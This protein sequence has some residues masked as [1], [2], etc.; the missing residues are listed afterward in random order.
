MK[1]ILE[2]HFFLGSVAYRSFLNNC[3]SY[4]LTHI[5]T[6]HQPNGGFTLRN[7]AE[8]Q[9]H[10]GWPQAS[11]CSLVSLLLALKLFLGGFE[12]LMQRIY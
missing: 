3:C 2:M 1:F 10:L 5:P 9:H 6:S 8:S 7:Q 12:Y 4:T 11:F